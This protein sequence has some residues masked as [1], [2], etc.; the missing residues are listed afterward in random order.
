M[1]MD[2]RNQSLSM[3]EWQSLIDR[4]LDGEVTGPILNVNR[5]DHREYDAIF[6]GGGA[7][8]RF[9]S[10]Y[11]RAQG[12]RQLTVDAWPFLGGSCP[13][14][15]CVP[16]HLFSDAARELDL[17]RNLSGRLFFPEFDEGRAS[18]LD[19]V[20]LFR[21][22][23]NSAHAFMNWQSKELRVIHGRLAPQLVATCATPPPPP[24]RAGA[25]QVSLHRDGYLCKQA[26]GAQTH[27]GC[28]RRGRRRRP[29]PMISRLSV[30]A[31]E[32]A[33][34]QVPSRALLSPT[35]HDGD[36]GGGQTA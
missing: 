16:H 21:R 36:W 2:V 17:A 10:A 14:Q 12:G 18:V 34:S 1:S 4:A 27:A 30:V 8:G 5:D 9:G 20:E 23:R 22:G 7:G 6:V 25:W 13:H 19:I 11:L 24:S 33:S 26:V 29:P 32:P 35:V 28:A 31:H 3:A 15:A